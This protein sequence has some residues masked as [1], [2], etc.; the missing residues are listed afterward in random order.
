MVAMA[1]RARWA[2]AG[3]AV[4][5]LA[6][7]LGAPA[8]EDEDGDGDDGGDEPQDP[9]PAPVSLEVRTTGNALALPLEIGFD[10]STLDATTGAEVTVTLQND[11]DTSA[12]TWTLEGVD[13]ADT[14]SVA[15]GESGSTTFVAPAPG[16]YAFYCAIGDHRDRGQE[17]SFTVRAA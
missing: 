5:L 7:C 15:A 9:A 6:G 10:P 14:G 1:R 12:H 2:L 4:L 8:G 11:D 3:V 16:E 17:G 13:G